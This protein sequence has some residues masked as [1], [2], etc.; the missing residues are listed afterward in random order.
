M[1]GGNANRL[2]IMQIDLLQAA[3]QHRH[4]QRHRKAK[5]NPIF[6]GSALCIAL[7]H[8]QLTIEIVAFH[9]FMLRCTC[10]GTISF[11]SVER[12]HEAT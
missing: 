7:I 11:R 10:K 8:K 2:L 3:L 1:R 4:W 12:T 6:I 9:A 5:T